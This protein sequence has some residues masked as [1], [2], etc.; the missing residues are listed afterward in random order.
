VANVEEDLEDSL[1][2]ALSLGR[3]ETPGVPLLESIA[4]NAGRLGWD[5]QRQEP[6]SIEAFFC[7]NSVL[8]DTLQSRRRARMLLPLALLQM[9]SLMF[10]NFFPMFD[11]TSMS[12][13]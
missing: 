5:W 10:S 6:L 3:L 7:P 8:S 2:D 13:P 1:L 11:Q 12:C 9:S 4:T